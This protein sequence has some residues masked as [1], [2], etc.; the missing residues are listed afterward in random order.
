MRIAVHR[1]ECIGDMRA[2]LSAGT[3]INSIFFRVVVKQ[4]FIYRPALRD[5]L[6]RHHF[7]RLNR[8]LGVHSFNGQFLRINLKY[9][10]VLRFTF[11]DIARERFL[12]RTCELIA[13]AI[14]RDG[15][16]QRLLRLRPSKSHGVA[17]S[18]CTIIRFVGG[19][20]EGA[21]VTSYSRGPKRITFGDKC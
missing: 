8:K 6:T 3:I 2:V 5:M 15:V 20:L 9:T 12:R 21:I 17:T 4:V 13:Q 18:R 7:Y 1:R 14:L 10:K 11:Y 19:E 16:E